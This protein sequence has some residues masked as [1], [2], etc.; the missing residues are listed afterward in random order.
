MDMRTAINLVSGLT[1]GAVRKGMLREFDDQPKQIALLVQGT[2]AFLRGKS[3]DRTL[4][5]IA[6]D[7][8]VKDNDR[9]AQAADLHLKSDP[10]YMQWRER[11]RDFVGKLGT[12]ATNAGWSVNDGGAWVGFSRAGSSP[13]NEHNKLY[14]SLNTQDPAAEL[15]KLPKLLKALDG[16]RTDGQIAFKIAANFGTF[17][18]HRDSV[19][20]HF[21]HGDDKEAIATAADSVGFDKLDRRALNRAEFGKDGSGDDGQHTSDSD[22]LAQRF[23]R[24]V[25]ANRATLEGMD[26]A[27]LKQVLVDLLKHISLAGTHR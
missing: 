3:G 24:N 18:S 7:L 20:I 4:Q 19:V 27:K 23:V 10:V 6:Y 13:R 16:I 22:L 26:E 5:S 17:W 1:E 11:Y 8:L 12:F 15:A 25:K 21:A 2:L 9:S 14:I